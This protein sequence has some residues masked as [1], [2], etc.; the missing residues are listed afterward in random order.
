[1][2]GISSPGEVI[3]SRLIGGVI[4]GNKVGGRD[5]EHMEGA[6]KAQVEINWRAERMRNRWRSQGCGEDNL[7]KRQRRSNVQYV[8]A[9]V[10]PLKLID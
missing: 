1:M 6:G 8:V 2:L 7:L 9:G 4:A 10:I 3:E 5:T